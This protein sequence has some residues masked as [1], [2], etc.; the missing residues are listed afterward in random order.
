M[1]QGWGSTAGP[2]VAD[3]SAMRSLVLLAALLVS[4]PMQAAELKTVQCDWEP[5]CGGSALTVTLAAG[6][7]VMVEAFVEH[8]EQAREWI[9]HYNKEGR[10]ISA[11]Y[12]QHQV[13]RKP[14]G[15]AGEFH[16][17]RKLERVEIYIPDAKG[18]LPGVDAKLQADF[19]SVLKAAAGAK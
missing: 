15:D 9:C 12:R 11:A 18:L 4:Q 5:A 14:L 16:I 13:S 17:E 7:P 6:Q 3:T 2:H 1:L 10:V 8:F 19:D